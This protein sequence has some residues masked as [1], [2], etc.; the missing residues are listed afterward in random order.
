M[1]DKGLRYYFLHAVYSCSTAA[2]SFEKK[3]IKLKSMV[4]TNREMKVNLA[5]L[6]LVKNRT[7]EK[8]ENSTN[9]KNFETSHKFLFELFHRY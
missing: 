3:F 4:K 9:T 8:Q 6:F 5:N 2:L 1:L 7:V